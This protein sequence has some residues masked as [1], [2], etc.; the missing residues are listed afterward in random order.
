MSHKSISKPKSAVKSATK[1]DPKATV[2]LSEGNQPLTFN[3][4]HLASARGK[5]LASNN[6]E[7]VRHPGADDNHSKNTGTL[8]QE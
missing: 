2:K 7:I 1:Q 8:N 3:P 5:H 6:Q 4:G